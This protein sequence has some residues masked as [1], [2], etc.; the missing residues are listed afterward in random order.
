MTHKEMLLAPW[1]WLETGIIWKFIAERP[2]SGLLG[3][4]PS[5]AGGPVLS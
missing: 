2:V 5:P 1:A 4:G 3:L